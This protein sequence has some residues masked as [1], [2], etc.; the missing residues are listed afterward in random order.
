M[1][2]FDLYAY[3]RKRTPRALGSA[4][5]AAPER[6]EALRLLQELFADANAPGVR[7]VLAFAPA[8]EAD[9]RLLVARDVVRTFAEVRRVALGP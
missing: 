1:D 2:A 3:A 5:R 7:D 8:L 4:L 9:D 6:D